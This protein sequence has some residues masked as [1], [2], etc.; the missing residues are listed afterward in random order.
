[1]ESPGREPSRKRAFSAAYGL[2]GDRAG[3]C[4]LE[5]RE[6][7][8]LSLGSRWANGRVGGSGGLRTVLQP[9]TRRRARHSQS[10]SAHG[11]LLPRWNFG[12]LLGTQARYVETV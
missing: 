2:S 9:D 7:G 11:W 5:R 1:M 4:S 3:R 10:V 12:H 8:G 6:I